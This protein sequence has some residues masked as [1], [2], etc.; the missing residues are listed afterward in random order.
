MP[1]TFN[2]RF[3]HINVRKVPRAKAHHSGNSLDSA[4]GVGPILAKLFT[5]IC[6]GVKYSGSFGSDNS[7]MWGALDPIIM[8]I[9]GYAAALLA[10]TL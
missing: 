4:F 2:L 9:T 7:L 8:C 3:N 6:S 1:S 5:Q 10:F